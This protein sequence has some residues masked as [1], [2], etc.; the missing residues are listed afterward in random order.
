M[1]RSSVV[2]SALCATVCAGLL[3]PVAASAAPTVVR[4]R[5]VG[6]QPARHTAHNATAVGSGG[7]VASVDPEATHAGLAVLRHG[8]NAVDAAVATAATLGVTE[9]FSSGIG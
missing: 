5:H 3:A 2:L 4:A 8:G 7:P 9:P 1:R 6:G